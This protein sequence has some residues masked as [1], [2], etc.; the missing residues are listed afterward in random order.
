MWNKQQNCMIHWVA[1][2]AGRLLRLPLQNAHKRCST[3]Y[4]YGVHCVGLYRFSIGHGTEE[5]TFQRVTI[6]IFI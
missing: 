2:C 6:D 1:I 3:P 4:R 5:W